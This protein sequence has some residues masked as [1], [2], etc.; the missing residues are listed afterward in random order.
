[1]YQ[2]PTE[3]PTLLYADN[4]QVSTTSN[5]NCIDM[6]FLTIQYLGFV[7]LCLPNKILFNGL[8]MSVSFPNVFC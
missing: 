1:M 4:S 5:R 8:S 3:L 6:V 7:A 2:T